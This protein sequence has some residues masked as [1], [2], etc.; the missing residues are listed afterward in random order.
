M[1]PDERR[2]KV[3]R[4]T[5][6]CF[7]AIIRAFK[8]SPKFL[9]YAPATRELWGR[10]LDF[11][12]RPA[13][14]GPLSVEEI[15]P[16]LVQAYFD[17]IAHRPGK[18]AAALAALKQLERWA[19][20]RELLPRQITLG[21]E[22]SPMTGGYIPWTEEHVALAEYHCAPAL[23]RVITLAANTGQRGSDLIR[24]GW[25][26]IEV[27]DGREG[28]NVVQQKTGR[29]VWVPIT[30]T[31]AAAMTRWERRPG[32]FLLRDSG[33]PWTR[34]KLTNAW[35]YERDT[36][37]ALRPL[38]ELGLVLHGLRG[39]ACVRL[40]RAGANTRQIS[41]MVGMSEEMV[42]RYTR[43]SVQRENASAAVY[44]LERTIKERKGRRS[45][46][47]G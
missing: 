27:Y 11:A 21:V 7:A 20:V 34:K 35:T 32:P 3:A 37:P 30:S 31:L 9:S 15:R 29:Q 38:K 25:T 6:D 45:T 24:M 44:H 43:F 19:I 41:D 36:N 46:K 23:A 10:E 40:L 33:R 2:R 47:R 1:A 42:A 5:E 18:Q 26:D 28:I 17:G 13:C 12:S 14:L 39:H 4:V 16:S 22:I 8:Q